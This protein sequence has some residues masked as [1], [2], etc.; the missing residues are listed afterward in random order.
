[1]NCRICGESDL[2]PL[3][4]VYG[5][6]WARCLCCGSDTSS[7]EYDPEIYR[8]G[9]LAG[10]LANIGS[11]NR[12]IEEVRTNCDW[13]E[14]LATNPGRDFLDVGCLEGAAMT[15]MASRGWSV[16]GFD[17]SEE[18]AHPGC[19]T[20]APEFLASLFPRRYDA[21]LCREVIEHVIDP[22]KMVSELLGACNPGGFVQI[23]TPRPMATPDPI[24]YQ[25]AHLQI[26]SPAAME[27]MVRDAGGVITARQ[28]WH[29]GQ[30]CMIS[31]R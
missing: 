14:R 23:Q 18:S 5:Q 1:M 3:W 31:H 9:Y 28:V 24:P 19:T 16:H 6:Q 29:Q 17:V 26:I 21:V 8:T 12:A 13:F 4:V 7:G 30:L 27:L 11:M 2:S 15:L 25:T 20:I 10:A 22:R